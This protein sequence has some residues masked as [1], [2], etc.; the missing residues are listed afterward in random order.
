MGRLEKDEI[1]KNIYS[2]DWKEKNDEFAKNKY[3]KLFILWC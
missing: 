1:K 2:R 3:Y